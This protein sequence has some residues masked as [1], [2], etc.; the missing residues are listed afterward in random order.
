MALAQIEKQHGKGSIMRLGDAGIGGGIETVPTGSLA[1]DL[2]LGVGGL[3]R[4]R[5]VEIYGPEGSGKTTVSLHVIAEAQKAGGLVS[6]IDAEHALDPSYAKALGVDIDNL[7]CSQPDTGEQALEIADTLVRSGAMDVIV[8]DSVAALVP[9]AEIEGEMGDSHVGL[10]ARL[11]SQALRKL[12]GNVNR[13]KTILIF[14]NQIREKI[15]VMFG[16]NETTP[17]GRAL[18]FYSS[19]RMDV[20]RIDSLKDGAEVVGSRVRVKVVK[21]K[22]SAPFKKAEF[23]IQYGYGISKEGSLLDV[24]LEHGIARKS[25]AWFIYGDDQLGQGRENAKA[26]LA[27]NA[28]IAAEIELKIKDKLGLLGTDDDTTIVVPEPTEA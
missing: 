11:M 2:A 27:A 7:L 14:I 15:G 13:S 26:F 19:V 9:R 4:G 3:P 1:L 16:S 28:D 22:V 24:A 23:D 6:F 18:K 12:A 10:Q 21:N 5:I 20:R 25:G 8:I 17:G